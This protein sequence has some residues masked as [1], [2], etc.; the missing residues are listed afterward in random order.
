M[1]LPKSFEVGPAWDTSM[2]SVN[3]I[4]ITDIKYYDYVCI[5]VN[6]YTCLYTYIYIYTH[7]VIISSTTTAA[8]I[9]SMTVSPG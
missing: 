3:I 8:I 4:S 5:Y 9:Y 1:T 6:T 2:T 7:M